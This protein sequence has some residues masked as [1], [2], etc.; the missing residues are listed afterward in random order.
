[1]TTK[2]QKPFVGFDPS[3]LFSDPFKAFEQFKLPGIDFKAMMEI[4]QRDF[5]AL[6]EAQQVALAGLKAAPGDMQ[7]QMTEMFGR[8]GEL[9]KTVTSMPG[10]GGENATKLVSESMTKMFGDMREL[11][12]S[13]QKSQVEAWSLLVK[14]AQARVQELTDLRA[15]R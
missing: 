10:T 13:A 14:R 8:V 6:N 15:A 1:M 5:A 3:K 12:E 4:N 9:L 7:T 11:A 2:N